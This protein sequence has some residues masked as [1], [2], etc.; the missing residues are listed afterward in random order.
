MIEAGRLYLPAEAHW[1]CGFASEL[2]AF[3]SSRY[4]DQVDALSQ[5]L[6]WVQQQDLIPK[7]FIASPIIVLGRR[8]W[9]CPRQGCGIQ[10]QGH[11]DGRRRA[12]WLPGGKAQ[13]PGR[14]EGSGDCLGHNGELSALR[15]E[16]ISP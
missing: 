5:L 8:D 16:P 3:P 10:S 11:V 15:R 4:D 9:P 13:A 14:F 7:A 1:L 12:A 2:L 6:G